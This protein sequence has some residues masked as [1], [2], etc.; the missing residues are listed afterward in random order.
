[1]MDRIIESLLVLVLVLVLTLFWASGYD[2]LVA[3]LVSPRREEDAPERGHVAVAG[4]APAQ[5][6]RSLLKRRR[7]RG[8]VPD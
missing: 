8:P 6:P 3:A 2:N 5:S 7:R 1:M 4:G